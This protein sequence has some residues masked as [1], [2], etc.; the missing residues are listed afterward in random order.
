[1]SEYPLKSELGLIAFFGRTLEEYE[2]MFE[3]KVDDLKGKTILDVA[4]GPNSFIVDGSLIGLHITG[5]DP[6]YQH[7][8]KY[9][10]KRAEDDADKVRDYVVSN[11]LDKKWWTTV[12]SFSACFARKATSRARFAEDY[13]ISSDRYVYGLLPHLPFESMTFD[14]VLTANFL[15]LYAPKEV[16]GLGSAQKEEFDLNF[17]I[18]STVELDRVCKSEIRITA[19]VTEDGREHPYLRPVM[20][21]LTSLGFRTELTHTSYHTESVMASYKSFLTATRLQ[22]HI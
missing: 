14:L 22:S 15:M 1:M 12:D 19:V 4:S 16:G 20:E 8:V 11:G 9:L 5:V 21:K 7:N 6:M 2:E 17:H 3:F 13:Q 18:A 10:T